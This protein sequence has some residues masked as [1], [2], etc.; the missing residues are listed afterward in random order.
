MSDTQSPS[1][2]IIARAAAT[3]E[4]TD[5]LGRVIRFKR[6]GV[7][8]QARIFKA[9]GPAQAENGPYV[10]LATVAASVVAIDGAPVPSP[11]NDAQIEA[12]I[13]RLGDD[14]YAALQ[15]WFERQEEVT[16]AAAEAALGTAGPA[17]A[18]KN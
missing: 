1:A 17:D 5:A 8:D 15:I 4:L 14:G 11:V 13:G 3:T 6:L 18:A 9:I 16:R 10:R 7:L 2:A 12:A